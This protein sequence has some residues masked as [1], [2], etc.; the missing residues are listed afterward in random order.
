MVGAGVAV[1]AAV[2]TAEAIIKHN[3]ARGGSSAFRPPRGAYYKPSRP[4]PDVVKPKPKPVSGPTGNPGA[5]TE[6]KTGTSTGGQPQPQPKREPK[7]KDPPGP[8]PPEPDQSSRM[9][10]AA[11]QGGLDEGMRKRAAELGIETVKSVGGLHS[12]ENLM[13]EVILERVG[14]DKSNS[15]PRCVPQLIS[16]GV[17]Y[18]DPALKAIAN[19]IRTSSDDSIAASM[20]NVSVGVGVRRDQL[21]GMQVKPQ[22]SRD[23][24]K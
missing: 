17:S 10:V 6:P 12:E 7:I 16:Q 24:K 8:P 4:T 23:E 13:R 14:S 18:D 9:F 2:V 3:S 15:C 21:P 11:S 5:G 1:I 19:D 22:S 20:R